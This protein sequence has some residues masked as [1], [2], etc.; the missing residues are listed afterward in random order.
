M[1]SKKLITYSSNIR[2]LYESYKNIAQIK[3]MKFVQYFC[4]F[5]LCFAIQMSII[6]LEVERNKFNF[7]EEIKI[8]EQIIN[9]SVEAVKSKET[10]M[11]RIEKEVEQNLGMRIATESMINS[12][13]C[14]ITNEEN[15]I[16]I[17]R[18]VYKTIT[19]GMR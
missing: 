12:I 19:G 7:E 8:M 18:L 4:L 10:I 11:K 14:E 5:V 2:I 17:S 6:V 9:K 3:A 16:E 1:P 15:T 13:V